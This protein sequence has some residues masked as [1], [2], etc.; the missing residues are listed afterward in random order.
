MSYFSLPPG[1]QAYRPLF[2][3]N[4]STI[5]GPPTVKYSK[6]KYDQTP[7]TPLVLHSGSIKGISIDYYN[8]DRL[9]QPDYD[10]F[11]EASSIWGIG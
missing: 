10:I 1:S 7:F 4:R 3:T 8:L 9:P 11:S 2:I 6:T 5:A